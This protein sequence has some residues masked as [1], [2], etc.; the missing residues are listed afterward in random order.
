MAFLALAYATVGIH[1]VHPLLHERHCDGCEAEGGSAGV[2]LAV[3]KAREHS[4]DICGRACPICLFLAHFAVGLPEAV[5][6]AVQPACSGRVGTA[7]LVA[8]PR[9][10]A[11]GATYPR[12]PPSLAI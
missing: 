8:G 10:V 9:H 12:A 5:C 3:P 1:A 7:A 2:G 6:R 4:A 11:S